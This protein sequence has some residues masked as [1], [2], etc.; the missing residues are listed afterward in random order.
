MFAGWRATPSGACTSSRATAPRARCATR[1]A[2]TPSATLPSRGSSSAPGAPP[3]GKQE[4]P[5]LRV[6]DRSPPPPRP[7]PQDAQ[8]PLSRHGDRVP[9]LVRHPQGSRRGPGFE[10]LIGHHLRLD[11]FL[12]TPKRH[13]P[14]TGIGFRTW[15]ATPREAGEA[16]LRVVDRSP[17]PL[18]AIRKG[19]LSTATV[20]RWPPSIPF[21][22]LRQSAFVR[23]SC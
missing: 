12:K 17:P 3:P 19:A 9:H 20:G 10:W 15:C 13:S 7:L 11:P 8:A 4:R 6:V 22:Q 18:G 2:S 16:L 23:S 5:W 1:S 14:V 21:P